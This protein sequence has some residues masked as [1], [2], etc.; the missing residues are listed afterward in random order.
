MESKTQQDDLPSYVALEILPRIQELDLEK[1]GPERIAWNKEAKALF[2][3][4]IKVHLACA[5]ISIRS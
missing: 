3:R 1:F 5:Y 2:D 4:R